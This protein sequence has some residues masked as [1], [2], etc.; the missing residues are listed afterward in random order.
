MSGS[1]GKEIEAIAAANA[2][3]YGSVPSMLP[4]KRNRPQRVSARLKGGSV[5]INNQGR[6]GISLWRLEAVGLGKR[7]EL[8]NTALYT[9]VRFT[10]C[11]LRALT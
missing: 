11:S 5:G 4:C 6:S 9:D 7:D 2:L 1:D 8:E 3:I 10:A